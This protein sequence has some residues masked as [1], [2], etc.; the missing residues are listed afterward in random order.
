MH[1]TIT[2]LTDC[3]NPDSSLVALE[4]TE[5]EAEIY[6]TDTLTTQ[7][8]DTFQV[9]IDP[10][11][12]FYR[13]ETGEID[14]NLLCG[15]YVIEIDIVESADKWGNFV[16]GCGQ[17]SCDELFDNW[18]SESSVSQTPVEFSCMDKLYNGLDWMDDA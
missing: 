16:S 2:V 11:T 14:F 6:M 9:G 12:T 4:P 17:V 3:A 13:K 10:Y 15:S 5:V 8:L 1:L 18:L 7:L